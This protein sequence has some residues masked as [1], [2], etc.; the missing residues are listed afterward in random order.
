MPGLRYAHPWKR[1]YY[2]ALS[3]LELLMTQELFTLLSR[4]LHHG[5]QPSCLV[6]V[7]ANVAMYVSLIFELFT[8][9]YRFAT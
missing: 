1:S 5:R 8:D 3:Q 6:A 2:H 7:T 4:I 9:P